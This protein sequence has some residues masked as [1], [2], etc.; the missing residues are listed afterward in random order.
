MGCLLNTNEVALPKPYDTD[1][2]QKPLLSG[3]TGNKEKND[4][5]APQNKKK[6]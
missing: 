6:S 1:N 3:N 4:E 2:K 5:P